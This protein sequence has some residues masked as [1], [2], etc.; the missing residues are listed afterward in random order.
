[1]AII[2]SR[3]I[4]ELEALLNKKGLSSY[5]DVTLTCV[6]N[7]NFDHTYFLLK[8][9]SLVAFKVKAYSIIRREFL[10]ETPNGSEWVDLVYHRFYAS[11]ED[12]FKQLT[13]NEKLWLDVKKTDFIFNDN[14]VNKLFKSSTIGKRLYN[15]Y[16]WHKDSVK[17]NVEASKIYEILQ[18]KDSFIIYY[19]LSNNAYASYEECVKARLNGFEVCDFGEEQIS[20]NISIKNETK[21]KIRTLKFIEEE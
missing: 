5:F 8:E 12:F 17:P 7:F 16:I 13:S 15:S 6:T 19:K 20:V 18:T 2:F 14:N 21:P 1:M 11:Q 3:N 10:I 4:S 9:K